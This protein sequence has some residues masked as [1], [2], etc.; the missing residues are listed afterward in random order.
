[1]LSSFSWGILW[2]EFRWEVR[3]CLRSCSLENE[4]IRQLSNK[5]RICYLACRMHIWF[6]EKRTEIFIIPKCSLCLFIGFYFILL[7]VVVLDKVTDFVLFLAQLTI[8]AGLG[9]FC[10]RLCHFSVRNDFGKP[11]EESYIELQEKDILD[12]RSS[13]LRRTQLWQL[14]KLSRIK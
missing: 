1:M 14:Q 2:G 13:Q 5:F 9:E 3:L 4:I 8:V 10:V 7:R 11:S 6:L 12:E